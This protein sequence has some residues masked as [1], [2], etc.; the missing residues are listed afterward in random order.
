MCLYPRTLSNTI[1]PIAV[2]CG[3][4]PEC[5]NKRRDAWSF[6][7]FHEQQSS[8]LTLFT[9]LSYDDGNLPTM[10]GYPVLNWS[11][12]TLYLKRVRKELSTL[13]VKLTYFIAGEYGPR[14]LRPHYHSLFFFHR[15]TPLT[16]FRDTAYFINLLR[17][18]WNKGFINSEVPCSD[19]V[20]GYC[21]KYIMKNISNL[22][23]FY[24]HTYS[25]YYKDASYADLK[26]SLLT[27]TSL[28]ETSVQKVI[29]TT[30][31]IPH[32]MHKLEF[33]N[34]ISAQLFPD[35]SQREQF[36]F[37]IQ[38]FPESSRKSQGLGISYYEQNSDLLKSKLD[39]SKTHSTPFVV[40]TMNKP[41]AVP[42]YYKRKITG[43]TKLS[44]DELFEL[45]R[46]LTLAETQH[47][48]LLL[49]QYKERYHGPL[50]FIDWFR[51]NHSELLYDFYT[52]HFKKQHD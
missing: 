21:S 11:D 48:T 37:Q 27:S 44:D 41:I 36:L 12:I 8:F 43:D 6:R 19:G 7:L 15:D 1:I 17:K 31:D 23:Q 20:S 32:Q 25:Y 52:R 34:T 51:T 3:Y 45:K 46:S 10:D 18:H 24:K 4:C 22:Y 49:D 38:H 26:H 2:D 5:I 16:D 39:Y 9:F 47:M 42:R 13:D 50:S 14:T 28:S 35:E 29:E 30:L 33:Y 40:R